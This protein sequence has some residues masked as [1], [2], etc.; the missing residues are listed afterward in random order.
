ML[1]GMPNRA[2]ATL[3]GDLGAGEATLTSGDKLFSNFTCN[4]ISTGTVLGGCGTVDVTT[5]QDASG[6][7]GII[8]QLGASANDPNDFGDY[9]ITYDVTSLLG[10]T[11]TDI[12]MFFNGAITGNGTTEVTETVSAGGLI[13]GQINVHN[14]PPVLDAAVGVSGGPYTTLHVLKDIQFGVPLNG[15]GTAS[16]SNIGQFI[17]QVP[18]PASMALFGLAAL[19]ATLRRRLRA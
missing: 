18:E 8:F 3:I 16:I 19:G 17:S 9:T 12:H 6:N 10:A 5:S 1:V 2:H 13:V 7:Y 4:F 11:I 15:T 14:P